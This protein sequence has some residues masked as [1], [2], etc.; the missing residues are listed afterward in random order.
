MTTSN[1]V[2]YGEVELHAFPHEYQVKVHVCERLRLELRVS[3]E[4]YSVWPA[5]KMLMS[6]IARC[7]ISGCCNAAVLSD[8]GALNRGHIYSASIHRLCMP[9]AG[10]FG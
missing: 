5:G 9:V 2:V 3:T 6:A 4:M 10:N 1:I 8:Q 7:A